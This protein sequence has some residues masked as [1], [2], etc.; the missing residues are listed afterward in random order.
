[1]TIFC[2]AFLLAVLFCWCHRVFFIII[3]ISF[4]G[5]I[6]IIVTVHVIVSVLV[7]V[8]VIV[9]VP[10]C[11]IVIH[12]VYIVEILTRFIVRRRVRNDDK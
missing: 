7:I 1:M 3:I 9:P 2:S 10:Y 4:L 6:N 8:G 5:V 12:V 11:I